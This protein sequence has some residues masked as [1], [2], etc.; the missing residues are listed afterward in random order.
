MKTVN[1]VEK[2]QTYFIEI[3]GA[4]WYFVAIAVTEVIEWSRTDITVEMIDFSFA[5]ED[6]FA[7]EVLSTHMVIL[8]V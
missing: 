7:H 5:L 3:L 2:N 4:E 6:T 1:E 8:S